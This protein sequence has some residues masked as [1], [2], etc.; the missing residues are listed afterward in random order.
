MAIDRELYEFMGET[1]ARLKKLE[2][3]VFKF[4]SLP[5]PN[6]VAPEEPAPEEPQEAPPA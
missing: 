3:Y 2:E 6:V 4:G 5:D 1:W